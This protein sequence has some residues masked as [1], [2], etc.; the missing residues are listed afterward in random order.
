VKALMRSSRNC[1]RNIKA[2]RFASRRHRVHARVKCIW[3]LPGSKRIKL[4][5]GQ[6]DGAVIRSVDIV[7]NFRAV[8]FIF[9][10]F[11]FYILRTDSFKKSNQLISICPGD[12]PPFN[13]KIT[14]TSC[15]VSKFV[16]IH[17]FDGIKINFSS[18]N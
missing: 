11:F 1:A 7:V 18:G 14:K 16:N 10:C 5:Q 13:R 4:F 15:I 6:T 12:F 9:Q 8:N 3:S 17:F 2:S